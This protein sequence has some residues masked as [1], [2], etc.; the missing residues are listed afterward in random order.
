[1]ACSL[2]LALAS[3][4][5]FPISAA[6][7]LLI[8]ASGRIFPHLGHRLITLGVGINCQGDIDSGWPKGFR[9]KLGYVHA[10]PPPLV[11]SVADLQAGLFPESEDGILLNAH[12]DLG[13]APADYL[14]GV[15]DLARR[16]RHRIVP[17]HAERKR[18]T[19]L[20]MLPFHFCIYFGIRYQ[21]ATLRIWALFFHFNLE[22]EGR[23]IGID[24]RFVPA[25]ARRGQPCEG[26]NG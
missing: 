9:G 22:K 8:Q 6:P 14:A 26:L 12:D 4:E 13:I 25:P 21:Y 16:L 18:M 10:E 2:V 17:E 20:Q 24:L 1:M 5:A 11:I 23:V 3:P 7:S 19:D 15:E